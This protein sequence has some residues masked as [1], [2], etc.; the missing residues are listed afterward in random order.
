MAWDAKRFE[1]LYKHYV[2][3]A[4]TELIQGELDNA[5]AWNQGDIW[6]YVSDLIVQGAQ[7]YVY[8]VYTP[9]VYQR[10]S[11][12]GGLAD[13]KN[14]V[15]DV[16]KIQFDESTGTGTA[17]I[18]IYNITAT[19]MPNDTGE[20]IADD[21]IAGTNY[22]YDYLDYHKRYSRPRNFMAVYEAKYDPVEAG[23]FVVQKIEGR[24]QDLVN[25]AYIQALKNT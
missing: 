12:N 19:G 2:Y 6:N 18:H 3:Q 1:E 24:L 10:R 5:C 16:G 17:P 7:R 4:L 23:N 13:P 22:R 14:V 9:K 20:Y 25:N 21:I 8:G 15:I 11:D